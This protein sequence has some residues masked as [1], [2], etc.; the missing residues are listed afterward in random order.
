MNFSL[1][2]PP[3]K[4]FEVGMMFEENFKHLNGVSKVLIVAEEHEHFQNL[5]F[6]CNNVDYE[7][8]KTSQ[9]LLCHPLVKVS[10]HFFYHKAPALGVVELLDISIAV[11]LGLTGVLKGKVL[12]IGSHAVF[13]IVNLVHALSLLR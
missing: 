4:P 3:K 13:E 11:Y 10:D 2:K 9:I 6:R 7:C 1:F 5:V 8:L 12:S